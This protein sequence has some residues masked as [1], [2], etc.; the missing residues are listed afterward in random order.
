M[1]VGVVVWWGLLVVIGVGNCVFL[2]RQWWLA[3]YRRTAISS[4]RRNQLVLASV[5]TVVCAFRGFFPKADVQRFVLW[6]HFLSSIFLGRTL[7]TIAELC[8]VAQWALLLREVSVVISSRRAFWISAA[9]FPMIVIAECA[10]WYAVITTNFMG[11]V[12][13]ESIWT[14]TFGLLFWA[15]ASL[16]GRLPDSLSM[17]MRFAALSALLYLVFMMTVDVP[18]YY[19]R[20]VHDQA[21]MKTYFGFWDGIED[22]AFSRKVTWRWED[23]KYEVPWMTTYFSFAV[24]I[25]QAAIRVPDLKK[26]T[27]KK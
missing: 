3:S 25:S 2:L 9:I 16:A 5:Y 7:S 12:V 6:D 24:W 4:I 19:G 17:L 18:G 8:F 15:A 22:A 11:N 26:L 10:S 13:E 23:W 14:L 1:D 27:K 21:Q 20:W